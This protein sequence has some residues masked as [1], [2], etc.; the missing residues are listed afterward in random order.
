MPCAPRSRKSRLPLETEASDSLEHRRH[1]PDAAAVYI[2]RLRALLQQAPA[3]VPDGEE[4]GVDDGELTPA[5]VLFPIIV[6]ESGLSVLL[7]QRTA[8]LKDHP[9]QISFPGGRVEPE[10]SSPA[11]TA[12]REAAE[13]IGLSAVHVEVL[14][15]LP[16]YRTVT[17]FRITPVVAIVTPPFDLNPAPEEVAEVFEVPFAFL[18]DPANHQQHSLN[19]QGKLRHYHALPYQGRNIWGATAGII[20]MLFKALSARVS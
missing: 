11:H 8:H 12:L 16:E 7:T 3:A 5:S 19:Y 2:D 10:D 13:E 6:R 20:L 15:C 17:G 1:S 18:M 14:G 4:D 9:G